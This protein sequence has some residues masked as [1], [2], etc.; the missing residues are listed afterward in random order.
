[1]GHHGLEALK[2]EYESTASLYKI[3]PGFTPKP[4]GWGSL[5]SPANSHFYIC[6]FHALDEE[7]PEPSAFCER[8]AALHS[9]HDSPEGKYGFHVVTYNGDLPQ[10]N[11]W[12]ETWEEFFSNGF[13]HVV[14]V[15]VERAG[16]SAEME[17]LLPAFYEKVIP[18]LL[19]PLETGGNSIKPSLVHGDLWCGNAAVDQESEEAIIYDPSSFWA[20][21]E[22]VYMRSAL[23]P[24]V[25][26][27][28]SF[29]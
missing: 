28:T 22:C 14:N 16:R 23:S 8:L 21:N 4:L 6:K 10:D 27:F 1:M 17:A 25:M 3:S 15:N 11:S 26:A 20:H 19:R 2:G 5:E 12:T 24:Q 18:R 9:N 7:L 29:R 13:K